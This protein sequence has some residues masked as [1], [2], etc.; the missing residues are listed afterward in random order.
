M[1]TFSVLFVITLLTA[2]ACKLDLPAFDSGSLAEFRADGRV[3]QSELSDFQIKTLSEWL[4]THQDGWEFR[5][6]DTP[7]RLMVT[8]KRGGAT[9]AVANIGEREIKVKDLIRVI[10]PDERA[11]LGTILTS[12]IDTKKE[13]GRSGSE[14]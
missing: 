1:K 3:V 5:V 8:L 9:V 10:T 11:K 4:H 13:V 12:F 6:E 2:C 14:F 7:P